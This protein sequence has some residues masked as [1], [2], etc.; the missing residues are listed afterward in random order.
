MPALTRVCSNPDCS[1]RGRLQQITPRRAGRCDDC[2]KA[3]KVAQQIARKARSSGHGRVPAGLVS[4][5]ELY[6]WRGACCR[7]PAFVECNEGRAWAKGPVGCEAVLVDEV[8][9]YD[10]ARLSAD[11]ALVNGRVFWQAVR[12][13]ASQS[14]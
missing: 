12:A 6:A 8:G 7:C 13:A 10:T 1:H 11:G 5:P 2:W 14:R 4:V 3:A 9:E